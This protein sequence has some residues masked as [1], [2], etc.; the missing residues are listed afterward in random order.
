MGIPVHSSE[1]E[2]V[3]NLLIPDQPHVDNANLVLLKTQ[4]IYGGVWFSYEEVSAPP[5]VS[6]SQ[7]INQT[8]P[9]ITNCQICPRRR[10]SSSGRSFESPIIVVPPKKNFLS[11]ASSNHF[12]HF[13]FSAKTFMVRFTAIP[14]I[15]LA[16]FVAYLYYGEAIVILKFTLRNLAVK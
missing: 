5:E 13:N 1:D 7:E 6:V 4:F 10:Q 9:E 2:E 8:E 15:F 12:P 11:Q 14:L 16:G 3:P